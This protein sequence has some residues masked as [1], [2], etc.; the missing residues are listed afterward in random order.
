MADDRHYMMR[1]LAL[2]ERGM[3]KTSPNPMVGCVI[4]RDGTVVGEGWHAAVGEPHAEIAALAA[5]GESAR[6]ATLYVTLEPCNHH[7]RTP[8][9]SEA[10]LAAGIGEIVYALADP[11]PVA[12]GGA[13]YLRDRG[14][15][16]RTPV[17]EKEARALNR[18]WLHRVAS[19]RPY[20]VAK[21]AVSLD[22][23]IAT[24]SGESKWI[25]GP[26]ARA[27][28]HQLRR[29]VDAIV[30]GAGT[31]IAD[32]PSLTARKDDKIIARPLRVILDSTGRTPP[33]AAVF[34]G[35]GRG[36]LLA[37]TDRTKQAR[38]EIYRAAG[39]EALVLAADASGRPDVV[40][41]MS[42]L[43][44]RGVCGVM[45]EGG[46]E[47]LGSFFDAGLVDEV[48]AFIAPVIIG[49]AGKAPVAGM[50]AAT[51]AGAF[52]L[53]HTETEQFGRD[54]LVR[55]IISRGEEAACSPA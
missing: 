10:L 20:V 49:G 19:D 45:V 9:C 16:V 26:E 1:A 44:E 32:D 46:A 54:L 53:E 41:L 28:A 7:G 5:A 35:A 37:T 17:C 43:K 55:G 2:A 38:L 6:G 51:I 31:V 18:F 48:W 36:A 33:D 42:A 29:Q 25:T 22:G 15:E 23:K 34:N 14:I 27:G 40:H 8:P 12:A 47:V 13:A 52:R 39:T 21:F 4:V 11:N 3:G 30:V 24:S 50:G